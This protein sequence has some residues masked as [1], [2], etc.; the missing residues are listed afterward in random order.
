VT[1]RGSNWALMM[2]PDQQQLL[3]FIVSVNLIN[4]LKIPDIWQLL[5]AHQNFMMAV[6]YGQLNDHL[7]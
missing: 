5:S 6:T 3:S 2:F 1:G 4:R 7:D